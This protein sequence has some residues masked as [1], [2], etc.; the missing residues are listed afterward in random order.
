MNSSLLERARAF[1]QAQRKKKIWYRLTTSM[2]AVVVFITTYMLILPA[3]TMERDAVCGL[4]EHTHIEECYAESGELICG[5]TVHEHTD[6]CYEQQDVILENAEDDAAAASSGTGSAG[7]SD[8]LLLEAVEEVDDPGLVS[9]EK[10]SAE[11]AVGAATEKE[12]AEETEIVNYICG[13]EEHCH[14]D[15][16]YAENEA[17]ERTIVCGKEEHTHGAECVGAEIET[18]TEA[19]TEAGTAGV[20]ETE[21]ATE[22][23]TEHETADVTGTENGTEAE[24]EAVAETE[25]EI[26]TETAT[27]AGTETAVESETDTEA[28]TETETEV[29]TGTET[30]TET[31]T[32]T[33]TGLET[34]TELTTEMDSETASEA[35]SETEVETETEIAT[36]TEMETVAELSAEAADDGIMAVADL[37]TETHSAVAAEA[38]NAENAAP[39]DGN[40]SETSTSIHFKQYI[41]KLYFEEKVNGH[42]VPVTNGEFHQGSDDKV[43]GIKGTLSY[44]LP[45]GTLKSGTTEEARSITFN[46]SELGMYTVSAESGPVYDE[47]EIV[48]NYTIDL[49]GTVT[50]VFTDEFAKK[51]DDSKV[52]GTLE[53]EARWDYKEEGGNGSVTVDYGEAGQITVWPY[54][55]PGDVTAVKSLSE[56]DRETGTV[57]YKIDVTSEKG[58]FSAVTLKDTLGFTSSE[59]MK[60]L[61][62]EKNGD[63]EVPVSYKEKSATT[64]GIEIEL[65]KMAAGETDTLYVTA[66]VPESERTPDKESIPV[67][68]SLTAESVNAKN[69]PITSTSQVNETIDNKMLEK[70]GVAVDYNGKKC[71]RWEITVNS[72]KGN[73]AD[74][75]LTDAMLEKAEAVTVEP[76]SGWGYVDASGADVTSK[77]NRIKFTATDGKGNNENTY[78]I[79]YYT[80]VTD[81][82]PGVTASQ[83]NSVDLWKDGKNTWHKDTTVTAE[84]QWITKSGTF[85]PG[86]NP[87]DSKVN[88]TLV[89]NKDKQNIAGATL[90]DTLF[91]QLTRNE[92]HISGGNSSDYVIN[93][94][95]NGKITDILFNAVGDTSENRNVYMITYSTKVPEGANK[96]ENTG[97]LTGEGGGS[98]SSGQIGVDTTNPTIKKTGMYLNDQKQVKWTITLNDQYKNLANVSFTDAFDESKDGELTGEG[99]VTVYYNRDAYAFKHRFVKDITV[100]KGKYLTSNVAPDTE[101]KEI[102]VSDIDGI[103][104]YVNSL[105]QGDAPEEKCRDAKY[106]IEYYTKVKQ[107]VGTVTNQA[108]LGSE[109][110]NANV[111]INVKPDKS[112]QKGVVLDTT[113]IAADLSLA[114]AVEG[115]IRELSWSAS[116]PILSDGMAKDKAYYDYPDNGQWFSVA[117]LKKSNFADTITVSKGTDSITL[118]QG[119]DYILYVPKNGTGP[120]W[121]AWNDVKDNT[122]CAATKFEG[123]KLV[124]TEGIDKEYGDSSVNLSYNTLVDLGSGATKKDGNGNAVLSN[125]LGLVDVETGGYVTTQTTVEN[126]FVKNYIGSQDS[127]GAAKSDG[128]KWKVEYSILEDMKE[129]ELVFTDT[130]PKG[131]TPAAGDTVKISFR[132]KRQSNMITWDELLSEKTITLWHDSKSRNIPFTISYDTVKNQIRIVVS[133][134]ESGYL[135]VGDRCEIEY[136]ASN[137]TQEAFSEKDANGNVSMTNTANLYYGNTKREDTDTRNIVEVK[138]TES[139]IVKEA[140]VN[141]ITQGNRTTIPYQV[142][143]NRAAKDLDPEAKSIRMQD[144]FSFS[145]WDEKNF[146]YTVEPLLNTIKLYYGKETENGYEKGEAVDDDLWS[147]AAVDESSYDSEIGKGEIKQVLNFVIPDETFLILEYSYSVS[148]KEAGDETPV[149]SI[150]N[151][152]QLSGS[153]KA[154]DNSSDQKDVKVSKSSATATT[155]YAKFYKVKKDSINRVLPGAEF[156]LYQWKNGAWEK[157]SDAVSGSDGT[158]VLRDETFNYDTDV[159]Y[160][161]VETKEPDGYL[162]DNAHYHF[163]IGPQD[164]EFEGLTCDKCGEAFTMKRLKKGESVYLENIE[165][166][167]N[168]IQVKKLWQDVD[169]NSVTPAK[170]VQVELIQAKG[171]GSVSAGKTSIVILDYNGEKKY[172]IPTGSYFDMTFTSQVRHALNVTETATGAPVTPIVLYE[173]KEGNSWK[174]VYRIPVW[175]D[176]RMDCAAYEPGNQLNS[177]TWFPEAG[178][179]VS[180]YLAYCI[181]TGLETDK[182][183]ASE[184]YDTQTLSD[185]NSWSYK[186]QN[187][188]QW[189]SDKNGKIYPYYYYVKEVDTPNGYLPMYTYWDAKLQQ[190]VMTAIP[191]SAVTSGDMTITNRL[192]KKKKV[193]VTKVWADA[194][195]V[196]HKD[197]TID[198]VLYKSKVEDKPRTVTLRQIDGGSWS[199]QTVSDRMEISIS[200]GTWGETP[201]LSA[202][203]GVIIQKKE[204]SGSGPIKVKYEISGIVKDT[205]L[206]FQK[207]VDYNGIAPI[208]TPVGTFEECCSVVDRVTL[209]NNGWT[210]EW[211]DLPDID[212][213]EGYELFYFVREE[214]CSAE[215]YTQ[216]SHIVQDGDDQTITITNTPAP[217]TDIGVTKAWDDT[218]D[219]IDHSNDSVQV[220]LYQSH[221]APMIDTQNGQEYTINVWYQ[222]ENVSTYNPIT[223]NSIG[224]GNIVSNGKSQGSLAHLTVQI[225]RDTSISADTISVMAVEPI[226]AGD[227]VIKPISSVRTIL[228]TAEKSSQKLE[229]DISGI[230]QNVDLIFSLKTDGWPQTGGCSISRGSALV[231]KPVDAVPV[232]EEGSVKNPVTLNKSNGWHYNWTKLPL[233]DEKGPLYYYVVE[234]DSSQKIEYT[235]IYEYSLVDGQIKLVS[236]T[237]SSSTPKPTNIKVQKVWYAADG[238]TQKT[239]VTK[240]IEVELYKAGNATAVDTIEL[241]SGH[242]S[243]HANGSYDGDWTY[244]WT[245]LEKGSYYVKEKNV[246]GYITTYQNSIAG[247]TE[248]TDAQSAATGRGQITIKNTEESTQLKVVKKWEG[249]NEVTRPQNVKVKLYRSTENL[250]S[251]APAKRKITVAITKW[252]DSDGNE[253][254]AEQYPYTDGWNGKWVGLFTNTNQQININLEA[255]NGWSA[256]FEAS[257]DCTGWTINYGDVVK[258]VTDGKT[259]NV[260]TIVEPIGTIIIPSGNEDYTLNLTA[261]LITTEKTVSTEPSVAQLIRNTPVL[262]TSSETGLKIPSNPEYMGEAYDRLLTKD[263]SWTAK[264]TNLPKVDEDGNLYYYYVEE[265]VPSPYEVSYEYDLDEDGNLTQVNI[266]NTLPEP[267]RTNASVKKVWR[268]DL[269]DHAGY[270]VTAQLKN[271]SGEVIDTVILSDVHANDTGS[272]YSEGGWKY[273]WSGLPQGNYTVEEIDVTCN[274]ESVIQ[275]YTVTV[276]VV[277]NDTTITNTKVQTTQIEVEKKWLTNSG[278][279]LDVVGDSMSISFVLKRR[280]VAEGAAPKEDEA[281]VQPQNE[282]FNQT[283]KVYILTHA[284][285]W[286]TTITGLPKTVMRDG[287][288]YNCLY[289]VQETAVSDSQEIDSKYDVTYSNENGIESGMLIIYN[290]QKQTY[291][292]PETGGPGT[293]PYTL[294]GIL[295]TVMASLLIC[296]KNKRRKEEQGSS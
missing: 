118:K 178:K 95:G 181:P 97:T 25:T 276:N 242:G 174:K 227:T 221:K 188:P 61:S 237:N 254:S 82:K 31:E 14:T 222:G 241:G 49:D 134:A 133:E 285:N 51:N 124:F 179:G 50:I 191:K 59:V 109:Q 89:I 208:L 275:N 10:E 138:P 184:V 189:Y 265:E 27:E 115:N 74:M 250:Y 17:G 215:G 90:T 291:A 220:Q 79:T 283:Q 171:T 69:E 259:I 296:I 253:I 54:G 280:L 192:K 75:I 117:E 218:I 173:K 151:T 251:E 58:T 119:T 85:V 166:P 104:S 217:T 29:V 83:T 38:G 193:K 238:T 167:K 65:E 77:T 268:D 159:P 243:A 7:A 20:T 204:E 206:T 205:E 277:G 286:K 271:A 35:E 137:V 96:V 196:D 198:V 132:D 248:Q 143:I 261:R 47:S 106:V 94:D 284:C 262:T 197:D 130:L 8:S 216:S 161:L 281:F 21:I 129:K 293:Q 2:A 30:E 98:S 214:N 135:P 247:S 272:G 6:A 34:A 176:L 5:R 200:Y 45:I 168:S 80:E 231:E 199:G 170:N 187:L 56:Y 1:L 12:T 292:L 40:S 207:G 142:V 147:V 152:A 141:N 195:E 9:V 236:I 288:T 289:Y 70:S 128:L 260:A 102:R 155:T 136:T 202:P 230:E 16:C 92:I 150:T 114:G 73:L 246:S 180:E 157:A 123:F 93:T 66:K 211:S 53:F 177:Q 121:V 172:V 164:Q 146:I 3:I 224:Y 233:E 264:W 245:N 52:D 76:N 210:H 228:T 294:G 223:I 55:V 249:D 267:Q 116:L 183:A 87:A 41:K 257:T 287:I 140:I 149:I 112:F 131:I 252:L 156:E 175:T 263:N 44:Q 239:N 88:W 64:T 185:G 153:S 165:L 28:A 182:I 213:Q 273:T 78:K 11:A 26:G 160:Y 163:Y 86:A 278:D 122:D 39:A 244:E 186:W 48:G 154:E 107:D 235:P 279:N 42:W 194:E 68:N 99:T 203:E 103:V 126:L 290:R 22:A 43:N 113:A 229:W 234:T 36:E 209:K 111:E 4:E 23:E 15:A 212:E 33:G 270:A 108:T 13:M 139:N 57:T 148:V 258:N 256:T 63:A 110:V 169:G 201:V 100:E 266:T 46:L 91:D 84:I 219:G 145:D 232:P 190:M 127:D 162:L 19:E 282:Q 71:I 72:S 158:L 295:L 32:E 101:E 18:G 225:D 120:D 269:S 62:S 144:K 81:A 24:T 105:W 240:K 255:T 125:K 37:L 67:N 274:G 60:V 226:K